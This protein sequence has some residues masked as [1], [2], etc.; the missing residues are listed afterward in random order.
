[1]SLSVGVLTGTTSPVRGS[2]RSGRGYSP[3]AAPCGGGGGSGR[4]LA[5]WAGH[6]PGALHLEAHRE[7]GRRRSW[8]LAQ[9]CKREAKVKV[10]KETTI[11]CL[12][13]NRMGGSSRPISGNIG[14]DVL[15]GKSFC[16]K[17]SG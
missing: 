3:P 17:Y 11:I 13:I 12:I 9:E 8:T 6:F 1:M 15:R 5:T 16:S 2:Q 14:P 4:G 7:R 10:N